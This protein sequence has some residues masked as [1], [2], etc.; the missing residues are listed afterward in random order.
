MAISN[1]TITTVLVALCMLSIGAG[2]TAVVRSYTN[3]TRITHLES[4]DLGT[5][6]VN[7]AVAEEQITSIQKDVEAIE[8][9]VKEIK[10]GQEQIENDVKDIKN[11]G[12]EIDRK[13]KKILEKLE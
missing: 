5:M 4:S 12:E 3:D 13:L 9:D 6:R 10:D 7:V 2:G 8:S 11:D 1:G